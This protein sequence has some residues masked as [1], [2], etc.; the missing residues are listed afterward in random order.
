MR[1]ACGAILGA[2]IDGGIIGRCAALKD[3]VEFT[4][5]ILGEERR[6]DGRAAHLLPAPGRRPQA[7]RASGARSFAVRRAAWGRQECGKGC[8]I[9]VVNDVGGCD[10][11]ALVGR[12]ARHVRPDRSVR[13]VSTRS[14]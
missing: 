7:P 10:M 8:D 13:I 1:A 3:R 12:D 9:A 11:P 6:C 2:D 5:V 14:P 4:P